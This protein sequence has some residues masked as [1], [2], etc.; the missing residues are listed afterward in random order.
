MLKNLFEIQTKNIKEV[1]QKRYVYQKIQQDKEQYQR[2]LYKKRSLHLEN[3]SKLIQNHQNVI[4]QQRK[5]ISAKA[6][7]IKFRKNQKLNY[8]DVLENSFQNKQSEV[9]SRSQK[10]LKY[11]KMVKLQKQ[12]P[13]NEERL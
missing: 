13:L 12:P 9:L 3:L 8:P 1:F 6:R 11:S 2:N 4:D 5:E 7:P 10:A